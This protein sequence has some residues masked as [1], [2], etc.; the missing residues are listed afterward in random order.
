L[1]GAG[2]VILCCVL[3]AAL[4]VGCGGSGGGSTAASPSAAQLQAAKK[5]GEEAARERDRVASL[6]RQVHRIKRQM[7]SSRASVAKQP[8]TATSSPSTSSAEPEPEPVSFH[9]PSGNVSCEIFLEGATC[10]VVSVGETFVLDPGSPATIENAMA[11]PRNYGEEVGF[12]NA[13]SDGGSVTCEVPPSDSPHGITCVDS[14]D[15]H[16]FEASRV[17]D[18]QQAY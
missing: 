3:A 6:Q 4:L 17:P 5:E 12:G 1:G 14:S 11:L 10:T 7:H 2:A 9:A 8:A 16:G 15:G 18:R 13:V